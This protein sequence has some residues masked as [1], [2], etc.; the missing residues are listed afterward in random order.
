MCNSETAKSGTVPGMHFCSE[1]VKASAPIQLWRLQ[2][3]SGVTWLLPT[4]PAGMTLMVSAASSLGIQLGNLYPE[5][6]R[7]ECWIYCW[8]QWKNPLCVSMCLMCLQHALPMS[9]SSVP[10][11]S[12]NNPGH[13]AGIGGKLTA[14]LLPPAAKL[15]SLLYLPHHSKSLDIFLCTLARA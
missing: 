7:A 2:I 15:R 6:K 8:L 5:Q 12:I 1:Y 14:I 9:C 3:V 10:S 4:W 11:H 13:V